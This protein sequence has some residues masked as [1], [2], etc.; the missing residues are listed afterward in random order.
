M[1]NQISIGIE[2]LTKI[3]VELLRFHLTNKVINFLASCIEKSIVTKSVLT[4][5]FLP[6]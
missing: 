2:N 3:Y 5:R 1:I 4:Y 6:A